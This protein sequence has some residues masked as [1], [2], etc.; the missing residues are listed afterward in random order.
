MSEW[1]YRPEEERR[2]V[3]QSMQQAATHNAW[4]GTMDAAIRHLE[5]E[6]LELLL[7]RCRDRWGQNVALWPSV[8]GGW[9]AVANTHRR[10]RDGAWG[11]DAR[12][13]VLALLGEGE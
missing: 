2:W 1:W 6:P 3:L 4:A 7:E 5:R 12:A 8:D 10:R 13:A 9:M 11:H